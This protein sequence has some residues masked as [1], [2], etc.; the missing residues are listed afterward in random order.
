MSQH[1]ELFLQSVCC[2]DSFTIESDNF[3]CE[4]VTRKTR[5]MCSLGSN[6]H[7]LSHIQSIVRV[8]VII[9]AEIRWES[10]DLELEVIVL[11]LKN[12]ANHRRKTVGEFPSES[13]TKRICKQ[14]GQQQGSLARL[15]LLQHF[16][17]TVFNEYNTIPFCIFGK[18]SWRSPTPLPFV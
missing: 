14:Q 3:M 1:T 10:V 2:S 11:S 8:C 13:L 7:L 18:L 17:H 12:F 4:S 16:I 5:W 15:W 9:E 6:E